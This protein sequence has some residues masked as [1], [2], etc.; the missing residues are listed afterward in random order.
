M[1]V[2]VKGT[3][4]ECDIWLP[5]V[6]A[7][8]LSDNNL[9]RSRTV[10]EELT[11]LLG[12]LSL[13]FSRN[14]LTED[15][16]ENM[17]A[18]RWLESLDLLRN[19]IFDR[20]PS[21]MIVLTFLSYLNLSYNNLLG[22]IPTCNQLQSF[23]DPSIHAGNPSLCGILLPQKCKD[24]ET[25]HRPNAI[26]GDEQNDNAMYEKKDLNEVVVYEHG[27][28]YACSRFLGYV[29]TIIV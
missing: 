29:W 2:T 13:N 12:L 16:T 11:N 26:G 28:G 22:R 25:N 10:P 21:S 5:L 27:P 9:S 1:Q 15:I 18:L 24:D 23:D 17:S 14:N 8:D 7:M 4:I 6:I 3:S 20:I 19:N